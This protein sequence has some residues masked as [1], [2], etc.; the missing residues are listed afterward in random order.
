MRTLRTFA[1][2]I[3]RILE[4]HAPDID[5]N[6]DLREILL[7]C[8]DVMSAYAKREWY[9]Y[10]NAGEKG[11]PNTMVATFRSVPIAIDERNQ[12]YVELPAELIELPNDEGV[13]QV[14]AYHAT[15]A[16]RQS[17]IPLPQNALEIYGNLAATQLDSQWAYFLRNDRL[18]FNQAFGRT[19]HTEVDVHMVT[20][21]PAYFGD[22]DRMRFPPGLRMEL[23]NAVL[24]RFGVKV[25][26][27]AV[28]E[29][30]DE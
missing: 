30:T 18:Y 10:R 5:T 26:E 14:Y 29:G 27:D 1:E 4:G 7:V 17:L 28:H 21:D 16:Q 3:Q 25:S 19:Q 12:K 6:R 22:E 13:Q 20:M 15:L 8:R 11:I 24:Q 9:A 2:Q 23:M